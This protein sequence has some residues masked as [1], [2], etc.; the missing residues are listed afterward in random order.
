MDNSAAFSLVGQ[1][2]DCGRDTKKQ[3]SIEAKILFLF[4]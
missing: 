1:E 3:W 4:S 2:R